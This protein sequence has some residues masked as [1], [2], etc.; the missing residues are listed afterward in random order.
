M[1]WPLHGA[2]LSHYSLTFGSYREGKPW[3]VGGSGQGTVLVQVGAQEASQ[4]ILYPSFSTV[5]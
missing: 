2:E 5:A 4:H 1:F 3:Q